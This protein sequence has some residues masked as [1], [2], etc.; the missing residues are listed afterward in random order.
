MELNNLTKTAFIA[1]LAVFLSFLWMFL[2]NPFFLICFVPFFFIFLI[3][4]GIAIWMFKKTQ[5][6]N[7]QRALFFQE[8]KA[9]LGAE[10][11]ETPIS[12]GP[13]SFGTTKKLTGVYKEV[14]FS[15]DEYSVIE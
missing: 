15:I 2:E 3:F 7:E 6:Q 13:M 12:V 9:D 11:I 5:K 4:A 14:P 1:F 8:L 10:L